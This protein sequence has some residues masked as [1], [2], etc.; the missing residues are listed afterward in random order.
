MELFALQIR[1]ND[2]WIYCTNPSDGRLIVSQNKSDFADFGD[3]F[4]TIEFTGLI[5]NDEWI[6]SQTSPPHEVPNPPRYEIT[7]KSKRLRYATIM[8]AIESYEAHPDWSEHA[9][10]K[11]SP[12]HFRELKIIRDERGNLL[13]DSASKK[14]GGYEVKVVRPETEPVLSY[15]SVFIGDYPDDG[16]SYSLL[17]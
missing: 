12:A 2:R 5:D 15:D 4:R 1:K 10:I 8:R 13:Y 6:N 16:V 3:R 14:V 11:V 7:E 9:S 17:G